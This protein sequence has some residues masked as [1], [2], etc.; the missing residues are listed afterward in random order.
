M[1][2]LTCGTEFEASRRTKKYCSPKCRKLA[3]QGVSVPDVSENAKTVPTRNAIVKWRSL[4]SD[5]YWVLPGHCKFGECLNPKC[6]FHDDKSTRAVVV[7]TPVDLPA[8]EYVYG[9]IEDP[10]KTWDKHCVTCGKAF[11]TALELQRF[12][13]ESDVPQLS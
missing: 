9:T 11:T 2:C 12:C 4:G 6:S 10:A 8:F 13:S 3:F 1:Q 5:G 7:P